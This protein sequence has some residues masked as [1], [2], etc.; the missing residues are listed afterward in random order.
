MITYSTGSER[1]DCPSDGGLTAKP[2]APGNV[3]SC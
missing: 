1:P 3:C 2:I